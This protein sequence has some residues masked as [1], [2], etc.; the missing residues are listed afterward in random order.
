M[1]V[2]PDNILKRMNKLDRAKL[3]KA[4]V[5]ASEANAIQLAKRE[6]D[7]HREISQWL[8]LHDIFFFHSRTDRRATTQN[9]T[10]DY[11]FLWEF[12]QSGNLAKHLTGVAI[13]VKVGGNKLSDEQE[14]VMWRMRDNGWI[15]YVCDSLKDM[16]LKLDYKQ[17]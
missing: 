12:E 1:T 16:L 9:G 17:P 14:K 4:G 2:L 15:Y 6:K 5:L 3:G 11:A 8:N 10:P 13:E 7:V